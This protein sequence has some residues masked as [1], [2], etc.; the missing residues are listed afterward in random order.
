MNKQ[1]RV[2]FNQQRGE[3]MVVSEN[4]HAH[5]KSSCKSSVSSVVG[6][7]ALTLAVTATI[8]G[9]GLLANPVMA[10]EWNVISDTSFINA[11]NAKLSGTYDDRFFVPTNMQTYQQGSKGFFENQKATE[12]VQIVSGTHVN[13]PTW[14]NSAVKLGETNDATNLLNMYE[15]LKIVQR[16]NELRAEE[17]KAENKTIPEL[18]ISHAGMALAQIATD[19]ATF[20]TNHPDMERAGID[21]AKRAGENLAWG[22]NRYI[23]NPGN[24]VQ[25]WYDEK[26]CVID[27]N[28]AACEKHKK[29]NLSYAE[30]PNAPDAFEHLIGHYTSLVRPEFTVTGAAVALGDEGYTIG[31]EYF[32]VYEPI[33]WDWKPCSDKPGYLCADSY[34]SYAK[35]PENI[36]IYSVNDYKKLLAEYIDNNVFYN[37]NQVV[38]VALPLGDFENNA[39][40]VAGGYALQKEV[41]N[42]TVNVKDIAKISTVYGGYAEEN[43]AVKN[44]VNIDGGEVI[45]V[46]GGNSNQGNTANNVVNVNNG[47]IGFVMGGS[48]DNEKASH[49]NT[50]NIKGGTVGFLDDQNNNNPIG[51]VYLGNFG[52]VNGTVNFLG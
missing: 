38:N 9:A 44:T 16:A 43:N 40:T 25:D 11:S 52:T 51:G 3:F 50:I 36:P 29:Q 5:G 48:G 28:S 1:Y 23:E 17:A 30:N 35:Q 4:T 20:E 32:G 7:A 13:K 45:A 6:K 26:D 2:I 42:N 37:E 21:G 49:N 34:T 18:K 27:F 12:A 22:G 41:R 24:A 15:A 19:K 46:Y 47:T 31:Q 39:V 14:F 10:D 33:E 8:A